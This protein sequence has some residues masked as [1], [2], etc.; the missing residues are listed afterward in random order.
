MPVLECLNRLQGKQEK[1]E[2]F[3]KLFLVWDIFGFKWFYG[4]WTSDCLKF[5]R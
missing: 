2:K 4:D 3:Y 1:F 5:V